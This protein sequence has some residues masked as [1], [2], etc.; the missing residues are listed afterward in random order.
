MFVVAAIIGVV[1][2][3]TG[4]TPLIFGM[5]KARMATPTSNF[6]HA[7][8]LMLGVLL[9]LAILVVAVV[10]CVLVAR[11]YAAAFSLGAASGLI[12]AAVAFGIRNNLRK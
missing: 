2:G 7:G 9:S 8:S 4:F 10:I 11:D 3:I 6:G 12:V 1:I 5:N